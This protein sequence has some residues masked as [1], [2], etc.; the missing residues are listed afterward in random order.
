M[1]FVTIRLSARSKGLT[2]TLR[3]QVEELCNRWET[4]V[5]DQP[6]QGEDYRGYYAGHDACAFQLRALLNALTPAPSYAEGVE[7][8]A[9]WHDDQA[10]QHDASCSV[11][12]TGSD[13]WKH[14]AMAEWTHKRHAA[15]TRALA[16]EVRG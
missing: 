12:P 10:A 5:R 2:M 4:Y 13:A 14:H 3:E 11:E 16:D 8:A 7:E 6:D 1:E 9:S 15:A